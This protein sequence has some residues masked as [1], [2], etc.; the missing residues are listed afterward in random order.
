MSIDTGLV[1]SV[2]SGIGYAALVRYV[3]KQDADHGLTPFLVV[4][5][6]FI[7]I[8]LMWL[9][10]GLETAATLLAINVGSGLPMIVEF[11]GWRFG[12]RNAEQA[13]VRSEF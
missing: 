1:L 11:Y 12:H 8:V 5:G 4:G 13:A 3:R 2:I 10:F 6:N 7:G 9:L